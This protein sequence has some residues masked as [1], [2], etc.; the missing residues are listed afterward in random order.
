[1]VPRISE[2]NEKTTLYTCTNLNVISFVAE[3]SIETAIRESLLDLSTLYALILLTD[4]LDNL[5]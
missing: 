2:Q 3:L 1:M 5:L 4:S